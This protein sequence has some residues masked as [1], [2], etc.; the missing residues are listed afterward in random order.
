MSMPRLAFVGFGAI[1]EKHVEVFRA[2]GANLVASC[3]RSEEGRKK[4]RERGGISSTYSEVA[5]MVEKERPEGRPVP[6]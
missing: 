4:A 6:S 1:A 5:S 2:L 3:N